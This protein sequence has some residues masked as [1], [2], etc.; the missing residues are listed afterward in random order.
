MQ[1]DHFEKLPFFG[2]SFSLKVENDQVRLEALNRMYTFKGIVRQLNLVSLPI[3][4]VME[5]IQDIKRDIDNE[6]TWFFSL[7]VHRY[8]PFL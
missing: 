3:Q 2:L 7:S 8:S 5:E 6:N 4:D 1:S